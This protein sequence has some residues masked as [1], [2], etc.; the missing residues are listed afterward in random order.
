MS[1]FQGSINIINYRRLIYMNN[2]KVKTIN[3]LEFE[4]L[5]YKEGQTVNIN[6]KHIKWRSFC[7]KIVAIC[8]SYIEL[9]CSTPNNAM[10]ETIY[11]KDVVSITE[12]RR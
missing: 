2:F 12:V 3:T 11:L 9:D 8:N 7:G 6:V 5:T 4:H 1:Q 10:L